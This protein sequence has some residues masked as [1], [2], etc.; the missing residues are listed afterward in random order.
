ML[1]AIIWADSKD[2]VGGESEGPAR[3]QAQGFEQDH[4]LYKQRHSQHRHI[5][6]A[7]LIGQCTDV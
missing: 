6:R 1:G 2:P 4:I 5:R 3:Q 7:L